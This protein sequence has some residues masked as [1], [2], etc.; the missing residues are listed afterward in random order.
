MGTYVA[1]SMLHHLKLQ[2]NYSWSMVFMYKI[3]GIIIVRVKSKYWNGKSL[4]LNKHNT[5]IQSLYYTQ[6]QIK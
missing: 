6:E 4:Y 3:I 1:C 2:S 5:T